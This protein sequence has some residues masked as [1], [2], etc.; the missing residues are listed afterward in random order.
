MSTQPGLWSEPTKPQRR[1]T[2]ST[3]FANNMSLPVHRW[4][5]YSAGFSA[6]WVATEVEKSGAHRVLDPFAGSATTLVAAQAVGAEAAGVE[7]HPFVARVARA[8]LHW[9][10]E[11]TEFITRAEKVVATASEMEPD[12]SAVSE[13]TAKCFPGMHLLPCSLCETR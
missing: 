13:L 5:R 1:A 7:I 11:P 8:K 2:N 6:D 3:T 10:A 4:F 12:T 9:T